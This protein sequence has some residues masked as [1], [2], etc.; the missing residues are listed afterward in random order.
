MILNG[1]NNLYVIVWLEREDDICTT[2]A[3]DTGYSLV[4]SLIDFF[5]STF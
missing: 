3:M 1:I 4:Y 2:I 5:S